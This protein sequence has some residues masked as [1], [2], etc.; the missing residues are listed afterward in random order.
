MA[1]LYLNAKSG[2]WPNVFQ[3]LRFKLQKLEIVVKKK[4]QNPAS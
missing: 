1:E 4:K 2:W 3:Q